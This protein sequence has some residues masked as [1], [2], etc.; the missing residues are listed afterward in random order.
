VKVQQQ[1]QQDANDREKNHDRLRSPANE[2]AHDNFIDA[3]RHILR[4]EGILG[5]YSGLGSSILSTASMN[6]AYF[7]WSTAARS[8]YQAT[9]QK[10]EI[11]D[12]NGISKELCLGAVGGALAQLC[13]NPISVISIRQQTRK[14]MIGNDQCGR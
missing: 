9:S 13:T 14:R 2:Y 3:I 4:E 8:L 10:F 6:F 1:R 12:S 11:A 7:Y 5:L